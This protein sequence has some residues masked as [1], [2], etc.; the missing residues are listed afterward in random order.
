MK[1]NE[2]SFRSARETTEYLAKRCQ[3]SWRTR[4]SCI[5]INSPRQSASWWIKA[6]VL[7]GI[8][9]ISLGIAAPLEAQTE[10]GSWSDLNGL[11]AGQGVEVIDVAM[12]RHAGEFVSVTD[13]FLTLKE[14]GDDVPLKRDK[15]VRV[16]TSSGPKRGAHAVIGLV[17]GA[18]IGAG[19][20]A[21][22][23][24]KHG[25]LG[26]S[27]RGIAAL[28]GLAIGGVSG[29]IVG[30]LLPAHTT[31]YRTSVSP[32]PKQGRAE[33]LMITHSVQ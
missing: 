14:K 15:V 24:S 6:W 23:G 17:A 18:A 8:L 3:I 11:R 26:G 13:E 32:S 9:T 20:G 7:A 30:G 22:S 1:S 12:K 10:K 16:S 27:S 2:H 28:V 25:F 33:A 19:I 5:R 4:A 29:T 31:V 21:A